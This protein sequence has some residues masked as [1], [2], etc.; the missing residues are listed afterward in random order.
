VSAASPSDAFKP[1][2]GRGEAVDESYDA[3]CA[4]KYR[5]DDRRSRT[6]MGVDDVR[7]SRQ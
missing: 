3:Y 2:F 5:S 1:R 4:K 6:G 7:R